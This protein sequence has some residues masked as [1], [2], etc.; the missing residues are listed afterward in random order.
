MKLSSLSLIYIALSAVV[1]LSLLFVHMN[2]PGAQ[3]AERISPLS[4]S[5]IVPVDADAS[6]TVMLWT[7]GGAIEM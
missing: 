3:S 4:L 2:Y 6:E 7:S 5:E 1:L